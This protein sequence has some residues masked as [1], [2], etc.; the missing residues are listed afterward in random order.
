M[1]STPVSAIAA[2]GRERHAAGG[3]EDHLSRRRSRPRRGDR[4][5]SYC[6]AAR[7]RASA[8]SAS[9]SWSSVS[10]STSILTRWPTL[11]LARSI[12]I[13]TPPATAMWLSLISIASSRPKRWFDPPP[14]RTAYFS[15]RPKAGHGLPGAGD[16]GAGVREA[17]RRRPRSR[18]RRPTDGRGSSARRAR[19]AR[20]ARALP[21]MRSDDVA[22]H[23]RL[24]VEA[25]RREL[26]ATRRS[27]GRPRPQAACP[28]ACPASGSRSLAV[29]RM[30]AGI[31]AAE[32]MSPARPRSSASAARTAFDDHPR[33]RGRQ[34]AS[35]VASPRRRGRGAGPVPGPRS[36]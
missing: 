30:S 32:V 12:A 23:Q 17:L 16:P 4:R 20:I 8:A 21:S 22:G 36:R 24:A 11:A 1:R 28:R 13:A 19:P 31:V 29:V 9:R 10:T 35:S 15:K 6:R 3:L 27:G 14:Q 18:S 25:K 34:S 26:R 2:H 7:R 5:G 33:G